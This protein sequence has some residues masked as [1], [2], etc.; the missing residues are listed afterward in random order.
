MPFTPEF[1]PL[2]A[3]PNNGAGFTASGKFWD[4]YIDACQ[5]PFGN[6][7]VVGIRVVA[8]ATLGSN[9]PHIAYMKY[10]AVT[11]Q[12]SAPVDIT[13]NVSNAGMRCFL[14][15][16]A[17]DA[18][19]NLM[20]IARTNI[21]V[22]I[23]DGPRAT[24]T[25]RYYDRTLGA[26]ETYQ[27]FG[28]QG[29]PGGVSASL[30][31]QSG[32]VAIPGGDFV[33]SSRGDWTSVEGEETYLKWDHSA[34][35]W[36][37]THG[38]DLVFCNAQLPTYLRRGVLDID[39]KPT[40][41]QGEIVSVI[42]R[43]YGGS[44]CFGNTDTT[45]VPVGLYRRMHATSGPEGTELEE[46]PT[47]TEYRVLWYAPTESGFST[48]SVNGIRVVVN[49]V[50]SARWDAVIAATGT[51]TGGTRNMLV[52][53]AVE[54]EVIIATTALR[55][56]VGAAGFDD[57]CMDL[58]SDWNGDL[59]LVYRYRLSGSAGDLYYRRLA[60]GD[61]NEWTDPVLWNAIAGQ[62]GDRVAIA[63]P[64]DEI[65]AASGA[66]AFAPECQ[67]SPEVLYS[68][69]CAN[70]VEQPPPPIVGERDDHCPQ[71][72]PG[73]RRV[74][75]NAMGVRVC[76]KVVYDPDGDN[77]DISRYFMQMR[78]YT[79][80]KDTELRNFVADDSELEFIDDQNLFVPSE[81]ES[82]FYDPDLAGGV[83]TGW[84]FKEVVVSAAVEDFEGWSEDLEI[85][86]GR[87][88]GLVNRPGKA[89]LR[90]GNLFK[91]LLDKRI[92]PNGIFG[93]RKIEAEE[94]ATTTGAFDQAEVAF[95]P[96]LARL[97]TW[98]ITFTNGGTGSFR[99]EGSLS[100]EQGT[101]TTGAVFTS[102]N[103]A[104][105]IDTSAWSGTWTTGTQIVF[106]T[107]LGYGVAS[108]SGITDVFQIMKDVLTS[109]SYGAGLPESRVAV[110]E[111]NAETNSGLSVN[112]TPLWTED[113]S[114]LDVMQELCWHANATIVERTNGVVGVLQYRLVTQRDVCLLCYL[115]DIMELTTVDRTPIV[116]EFEFQYDYRVNSEGD[117]GYLVTEILPANP[118]A[119]ESFQKYGVLE[120][121]TMVLRGFS[122]GQRANVETLTD[123]LLRQYGDPQELVE[124]RMKIDRL[125]LELST[126]S[127]I[128]VEY[129]KLSIIVEPVEISKQ[130]GLTG[131]EVRGTFRRADFFIDNS[132]GPLRVGNGAYD[133]CWSWG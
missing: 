79:V 81:P 100:G 57:G 52:H 34:K 20:V 95:T 84:M 117:F 126:I 94:G 28:G 39:Y 38:G 86:R 18:A 114:V 37:G 109:T 19:G 21:V 76:S 15:R 83:Q 54:N 60:E 46:I 107:G 13:M 97:E 27:Q 78:P 91:H 50:N 64:P 110:N 123:D 62:L 24:N 119:N 71:L 125:N 65:G 42:G 122:A 89:T 104:I 14:P 2:A 98:T 31:P 120:R 9:D 3:V 115:V 74:L 12:W 85:F 33:S 56:D 6:I 67:T 17:S 82:L 44:D 29:S 70:C 112:I 113:A 43:Q 90:L 35:L 80:R 47:L 92:G 101:G 1:A 22:G 72:P 26:W 10:D 5:D 59:H 30:F 4:F 58:E 40:E 106:S 77:I 99:V 103:G 7:H 53:I 11:Q 132:C 25:S 96:G 131:P 8:N 130:I 51:W 69:C 23:S 87:I 36:L 133:N 45:R 128:L 61:I 121:R 129:P 55:D 63:T 66:C 93:Y 49:K 48:W 116:N 111:F 124:L 32:L 68:S 73:W 16:I 127:R 75:N 102:T 88:I 118:A 41:T 108:P 105:I